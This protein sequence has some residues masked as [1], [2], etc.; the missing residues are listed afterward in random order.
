MRQKSLTLKYEPASEPLLISVKRV[1][2]PSE[3]YR[4]C[5]A[6]TVPIGTAPSLSILRVIH[7][8][9]HAMHKGARTWT[10]RSLSASTTRRSF[11]GSVLPSNGQLPN[12]GYFTAQMLHVVVSVAH[13]PC[14]DVGCTGRWCCRRIAGLVLGSEAGSYLRLLDYCIT[15]ATRLDGRERGRAGGADPRWRPGHRQNPLCYIKGG[16][17]AKTAQST[18]KM[19]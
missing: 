6:L 15:E 2:L 3:L 14:T 11:L 5:A 17:H 1:F 9:A 16:F 12:S 19:A 10:C 13:K 4:F 7:R 18:R 8:G